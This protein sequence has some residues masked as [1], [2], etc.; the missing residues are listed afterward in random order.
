LSDAKAS[1]ASFRETFGCSPSVAVITVGNLERYNH[2]NRR[3]Q[4]DSNKFSLW[5]SKSS[6]GKANHFDVVKEV[7]LDVSTTI[8]ELLSHIY[9]LTSVHG[10]QLMWPLLDHI[11]DTAKVYSV[12]HPSKDVDGIHHI[13]QL[14]IRN[15]DA[16][17]LIT[18]AA[19]IDL[20]DEFRV[21]TKNK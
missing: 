2:V 17:P 5:F 19:T 20:M 8:D 11:I 15:K 1:A 18:Q 4:I 9:A 7:N 3:F 13:G 6:N 21:D 16:Y 12:I 10:I 14:E